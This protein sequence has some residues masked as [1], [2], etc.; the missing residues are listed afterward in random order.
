MY[1][2][3]SEQESRV[4]YVN[5]GDGLLKFQIT[6]EG[7]DGIQFETGVVRAEAIADIV[8]GNCDSAVISCELGNPSITVTLDK[9]RNLVFTCTLAE[10]R[11]PAEQLISVLKAS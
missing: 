11:L 4:D 10:I 7:P 8:A 2:A 9:D 5:L 1:A 6:A 3:D